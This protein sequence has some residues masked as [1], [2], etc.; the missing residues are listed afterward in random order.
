MPDA[1]RRAI[2][3]ILA[4]A[5]G[6]VPAPALDLWPQPQQENTIFLRPGRVSQLLGVTI[7]RPEVE[8]LLTAVGFFVAPKDER[9]AVQV[10]GWR[11]DVTREVD[12]IEEVA[13]LK[14]YDA[15]P[16]ELRAY[17][18]GTV[19]DAPDERARARARERLVRAGLL[20]ARTFPLGPPDGPD[21]V[22]ILNPM[23]AEEAHLRR[24][25]LPGL[26]RR[27]EYNWANRN[28]DIRLFEVGTVFRKAT[29]EPAQ[30]TA[31]PEEWTSVAAVLTGARRPPH[32][33]EGAKVPDMD[34]WDL[35]YH[36]ELAVSVAAPSCDV[37]PATGGVV[38]WE[39][40]QRG[41]GEVMGWA[42][43]LEADAPVWAAPLLGFEVRLTAS[44]PAV[45]RYR[46]LPLQP[47]VERD[48]ALVVPA[49]V[50]A[51]QLSRVLRQAVGP[52]L[53]QL[54][55]FDEYRGPGIPAGHRGVA[56]HCTFRDPERTL[57]ERDV[58]ALLAR[59]LEAL[60]GE[61]GVRRRES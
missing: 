53:E 5:G 52:L 32:W 29:G 6:E 12:L 57:R 48:L 41:G 14:G 13:R 37:R 59:G 9:L 10:P 4:V 28:R 34:I 33:S 40:V 20:E 51:A 49:G 61:L 54:E 36:F 39:A 8:R 11:P 15:F 17:R 35:K 31:A 2:E 3:L 19:P 38:G 50:T 46:P 56:W 30:G 22:P 21:A 18:P 1:L 42:G 45:V 27:I 25:L 60:E 47:P 26:V 24:R 58:D 43:P 16:D 7:E 55:V 23:S 44:E